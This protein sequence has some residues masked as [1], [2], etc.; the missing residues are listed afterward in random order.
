MRLCLLRALSCPFP[1]SSLNPWS[2]IWSR[3]LSDRSVTLAASQAAVK[4]CFVSGWC[5]G[6]GGDYAKYE[7][8]FLKRPLL[9]RSTPPTGWSMTRSGPPGS[10]GSCPEPGLQSPGLLDTDIRPWYALAH[11]RT[12]RSIRLWMP[13]YA[14]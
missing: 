2:A 12:D 6:L 14:T 9:Q 11:P 5:L 7:A 13:R 1:L 8:G 3:K 4:V 10:F